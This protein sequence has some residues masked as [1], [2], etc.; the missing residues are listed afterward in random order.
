MIRSKCPCLREQGFD[1]VWKWSDVDNPMFWP[2]G[3]N[4]LTRTD[5]S[6]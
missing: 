3:R 6:P 4:F 1:S 2:V 5:V